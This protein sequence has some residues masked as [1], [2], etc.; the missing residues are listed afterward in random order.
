MDLEVPK[1]ITLV[2]EDKNTIFA[3]DLFF[4]IIGLLGGIF[5]SICL[6][7]QIIKIYKNNPD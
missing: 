6:I 1:L 4:D 7:P 3:F 5:L 2:T